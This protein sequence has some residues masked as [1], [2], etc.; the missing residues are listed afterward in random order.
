LD[1]VNVKP[2]IRDL[3]I[4]ITKKCNLSCIYCHREGQGKSHSSQQ[5]LSVEEI[6]LISD[7]AVKHGVSAIKITGGEPLVRE[8]I[9]DMIHSIRKN[10]RV[11]DLSL[12]TNGL[13]LE[14]Y[15]SK[16]KEGGLDRINVSLDTLD[17]V[18]YTRLSNGDV[19]KVLE[20]ISFAASLQF[21][22][23]KI[24]MLILKNINDDDSIFDIIDFIETLMKTSPTPIHL[25]LIELVQTVA[26][27]ENFFKKHFVDLRER[28]RDWLLKHSTSRYYRKKNMRE[29]FIMKGGFVIELVTPT[30]NST[31]CEHCSRLRVTADGFLKPCLMREDNLVDIIG[32]IRNGTSKDELLDIFSKAITYKSPYWLE[33]SNCLD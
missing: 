25:Q 8:D 17:P 14:K 11:E 30:H 26:L 28:Y 29:C 16:L 6:S 21:T 10:K 1:L 3:R 12:V 13:L 23:I 4:S 5:P 7:L 15:A 20:G 2:S 19:K 9:I 33:H 32:P 31:F 27:D 18:T 22:L 24:N